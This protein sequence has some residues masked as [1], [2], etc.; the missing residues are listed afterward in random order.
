MKIL[1]DYKI[2]SLNNEDIAKIEI[3]E[4]EIFCLPWSNNLLKQ[5]FG[6]KNNILLGTFSGDNLIGYL[7]ASTIFD[8]SELLRLAV[9]SEFRGY[10]LA[11]KM[12][13]YYFTITQQYQ[14]FYLEVG[15]DNETAKTLYLSFGYV[16]YHTRKNYYSNGT[17]ALL[18]KRE[19]ND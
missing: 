1:Q 15:E 8:E 5:I 2:K 4:K 11:K 17:S 10:G 7:I 3:M 6:N 12:L 9:L 16:V 13:S 19:S 18:M 14:K